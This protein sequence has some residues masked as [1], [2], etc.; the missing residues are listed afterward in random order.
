MGNNIEKIIDEKILFSAKQDKRYSSNN[1]CIMSIII[2]IIAA[3]VMFCL[4]RNIGGSLLV[5]LALDILLGGIFLYI[6]HMEDKYLSS[7]I[8]WAVSKDYFYQIEDNIITLKIK[9]KDCYR[10]S[11]TIRNNSNIIHLSFKE[12]GA[13]K[14]L[15]M[16]SVNKN[17]ITKRALA[18]WINASD[19]E[20]DNF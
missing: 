10:V 12:K 2:N 4:T 19:E 11:G 3:I 5:L 7:N 1:F 20:L 15:N 16:L 14:E 17:N 18:L 9:R 8:L 13:H 6:R